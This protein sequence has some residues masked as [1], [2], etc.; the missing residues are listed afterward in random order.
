M[1]ILMR[2][3]AYSIKGSMAAMIAEL[4]CVSW[5]ARWVWA[6]AGGGAVLPGLLRTGMVTGVSSGGVRRLAGSGVKGLGDVGRVWP[7]WPGA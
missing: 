7:R 6:A 1:R 5:L 4:V 2:S 3:L